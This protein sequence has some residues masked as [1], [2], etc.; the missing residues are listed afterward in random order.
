MSAR[1]VDPAANSPR[2]VRVKPKL[3]LPTPATSRSPFSRTVTD[4]GTVTCA[5]RWTSGYVMPAKS[6]TRLPAP[7]QPTRYRAVTPTLPVRAAHV[8]G[9]RGVVLAQPDHLLA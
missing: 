7:S 9:H 4:S 2:S 1:L 8:R 3:I 5:S 6:R